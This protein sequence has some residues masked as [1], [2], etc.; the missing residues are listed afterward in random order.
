[1]SVQTAKNNTHTFVGLDVARTASVQY[2]DSQI[3]ATYL[4]DGEI[5]V[6]GFD[7]AVLT[8]AA[9]ITT[10]P[11]IRLVMRAGNDLIYSPWIRG[12]DTVA[13]NGASY[14]APVE[15]IYTIGYNGNAGSNIDTATTNA[16]QMNI[17]YT[18]DE[19][20]WSEQGN[21][22]HYALDPAEITSPTQAQVAR[23]F[24]EQINYNGQS[25]GIAQTGEGPLIRAEILCDETAVLATG[26]TT[27]FTV[28]QGS[29][30]VIVNGTL[31][32]IAVGDY[33]R[34]DSLATTTDELYQVKALT[35]STS[36][37]LT[38]PYQGTSA[39]KAIA[40]VGRVLEATMDLAECGVRIT[41]QPAK[42]TLDFF[43]YLQVTFR[44][45]LR[46][47][48]TS[49]LTAVAATR[50][51]GAPEQIAELESFSLGF[52]GALNRTVVPL[53]TGRS[54]ADLT[55]PGTYD[56]LTL[57]W[58]DKTDVSAISGVAPSMQTVHVAEEV[59]A[60]QITDAT[61]GVQ[62]VL[63]AWTATCPGAFATVT[64]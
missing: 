10:D 8:N 63:N 62:T 37:Q 35:A 41:A 54:H 64:V 4:A 23:Y 53:P 21:Y 51:T 24:A 47:F 20:M 55:T 59:G 40:V 60:T 52:E 1:M 56:M 26:T 42:W 3:A 2:S 44:V 19:S 9:T 17:S 11:K 15:Q 13:W 57:V 50:P 6:T 28:R 30:M 22:E 43:K 38:M 48:L 58:A 5:L 12:V 36:I 7:G 39:V 27:T 33:I 34:F 25:S 32:N 14:V 16:Y 31:T 45:G 18:F 29:D 61:T 49:T 46:N